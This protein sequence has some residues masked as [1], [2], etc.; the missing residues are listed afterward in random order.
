M[1]RNDFIR[2]IGGGASFLL[3]GFGTKDLLYDLQEI[4]IYDNYVRGTHFYRKDFKKLKL[5]VG[6]SLGLQREQNNK[7]DRFAI[8][9]CTNNLKI[10][11]IPAYE[12]VVL[13]NMMDKGVIAA[14]VS[15]LNDLNED[16]YK[17]VV[18]VKIAARLMVPVQQL[19]T[20]DLTRERADNAT[21]IYRKGLL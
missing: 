16:G 4:T 7:Y 21:D 15:E 5:V 8:A 19:V 12:N 20:N 6:Q 18:A 17:D 2:L 13:A 9:V 11:Y 14:I 10:G 3:S 1:D